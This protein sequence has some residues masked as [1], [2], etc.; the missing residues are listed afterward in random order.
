MIPVTASIGWDA[1]R[2]H[3]LRSALTMLGV[4]IGVAAVVAMV[5]I[6]RGARDEIE[7]QIRN[8]G[9]NLIGISQGSTVV[10]GTR[11]GSGTSVKL[12][13]DDALAIGTEVPGIVAVAPMLYSRPQFSAG[14][15]NWVGRVNGVTPDYFVVREWNVAQGREMI[16]EDHSRVANV[17]LLGAVIRDKLFVGAEPIGAVVRIQ[18][19]P[20][21]VIGVL[22]RKGQ[23]IWGNDEDDVAL[24][25]LSTARRRL[26]GV[27]LASPRAVHGITVKFASGVSAG[28]TMM[29]I[30]DLLRERHRLKAGQEEAFVL[31]DLAEV[32]GVEHATTHVMST[33]LAA[34]ASVSLLVGGIGIMNIML[35]SVTERTREIGLRLAVGA[36][37][38]DIL[39]QFL[40]EATTLSLL[41]GG[42]GAL[43][44]IAGSFAIAH[45][46]GWPLLIGLGTVLMAMAF[47][48]AIGV[49]FGFY[50]AR[51]AARLDPIE[52]LRYE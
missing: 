43:V 46:A 11:L 34:V 2:A 37:R 9:S 49:F 27:N 13:E 21:T 47:A 38:R 20:F 26:V 15:S 28:E 25:P 42:V 3:R 19:V 41:G 29:A 48:G 5:A 22:D 30:A 40:V 45:L 36:R 51:Q 10:G 31:R 39:A 17:V 24:V 44:G 50:P 16:P 33:L 12:S 6:G 35:V 32:A 23:S 8:L 52:A 7:A 1:L 14:S 18:G 4:I